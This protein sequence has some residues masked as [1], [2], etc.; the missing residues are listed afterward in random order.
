MLYDPK[1]EVKTDSPSL[2]GLIAWLEKQPPN[3]SYNWSDC[4]GHCLIGQYWGSIGISF[5]EGCLMELN[6]QD[7][8][9]QLVCPNGSDGIAITRPH[10]FGAALERARAAQA[11]A[12]EA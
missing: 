4:E 2:S 9:G 12:E 3:K 7:L 10:T 11:L 1:W 6:G 5:G 8:Y